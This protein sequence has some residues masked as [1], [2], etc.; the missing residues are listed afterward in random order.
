MEA[1]LIAIAAID[2]P[3]VMTLG[4]AKQMARDALKNDGSL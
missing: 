1:T 3:D 2:D 4:Y